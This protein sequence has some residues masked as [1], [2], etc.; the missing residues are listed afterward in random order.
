MSFA[1]NSESEQESVVAAITEEISM[2]G[3]LDH[4]HLVRCLGATRDGCHFNIF[5]EWMPG[6]FTNHN[7]DQFGYEC[8]CRGICGFNTSKVW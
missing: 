1:R 2:M 6:M 5:M 4:P 8:A 3:R 7:H